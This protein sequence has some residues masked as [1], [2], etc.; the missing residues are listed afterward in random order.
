MRRSAKLS[1]LN[2][3]ASFL[4]LCCCALGAAI[5]LMFLLIPR[6][7]GSGHQVERLIS[8]VLTLPVNEDANENLKPILADTLNTHSGER[9][10]ITGA[11][12]VLAIFYDGRLEGSSIVAADSRFHQRVGRFDIDVRRIAVDPNAAERQQLGYPPVVRTDGSEFQAASQLQVQVQARLKTRELQVSRRIVIAFQPDNRDPACPESVVLWW[13]ALGA[14]SSGA[15]SAWDQTRLD[16]EL[17]PAALPWTAPRAEI[18]IAP[19]GEQTS[20]TVPTPWLKT[21]NGQ[22]TE[23]LL[24]VP[25]MAGD[26]EWLKGANTVLLDATAE[27]RELE[28]LAD[29]PAGR[30]YRFRNAPSGSSKEPFALFITAELEPQTGPEG[31]HVQITRFELAPG[32]V[33]APRGSWEEVPSKQP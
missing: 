19:E 26:A 5:L 22:P 9:Q 8:I 20:R 12:G 29:D 27:Q 25:H 24:G 10:L 7:G 30:R 15:G 18:S 23:L 32:P 4:D 16:M 13:R 2:L 33:G 21:E 28:R 3:S 17:I 31:M 11:R 14:T 6:G 1:S